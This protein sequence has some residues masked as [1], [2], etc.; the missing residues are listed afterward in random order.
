M[1]LQIKLPDEGE[2]I[3]NSFPAGTRPPFLGQG[4]PGQRVHSYKKPVP[5]HTASRCPLQVSPAHRMSVSKAGRCFTLS[6]LAI[7]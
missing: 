4:N 1:Q 7:H 3:E 6:I 2:L 5:F